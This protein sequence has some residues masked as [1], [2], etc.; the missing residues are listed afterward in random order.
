MPFQDCQVQQQTPCT[1]LRRQKGQQLTRC[2]HQVGSSKYPQLACNLHHSNAPCPYPP[3][4]S[5]VSGLCASTLPAVL[6]TLLRQHGENARHECQP[7][8]A[9]SM[10][11]FHQQ[12]GCNL[13]WVLISLHRDL[14]CDA[15]DFHQCI[16]QFEAIS[17]QTSRLMGPQ[18]LKAPSL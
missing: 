15:P 8:D 17:S 11:P 2:R 13:S 12:T 9:H 18:C 14:Q 6:P 3:S 1:K 7:W 10:F 4:Q 5:G 16:S